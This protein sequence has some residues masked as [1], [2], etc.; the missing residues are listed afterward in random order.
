MF[1][2]LYAFKIRMLSKR[3]QMNHVYLMNIST[4]V[5]FV[6]YIPELYANYRNKNANVYNMPEKVLMVMGSG[7]AL[8]YA[9]MNS[10]LALISNYGP[11]L[12]LDVVALLMRA[13]YVY[14]NRNRDII[15]READ[16][17]RNEQV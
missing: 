6:C 2:L 3:W 15:L 10:D 4:A 9:L 16:S 7:F 12:F 1:G 17:P 5:F 11:I 13:Y 8:S 14:I